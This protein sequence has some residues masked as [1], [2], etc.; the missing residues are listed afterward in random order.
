[1]W[2][3]RK[4]QHKVKWDFAKSGFREWKW[5]VGWTVKDVINADVNGAVGPG[6]RVFNPIT[7]QCKAMPGMQIDWVIL[8]Q[9]HLQ[10]PEI[11]EKTHLSSNSFTQGRKVWQD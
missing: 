6:V 7:Y 8:D 1:M 2:S 5:D 4:R 11:N 9:I 10:Q 3:Y